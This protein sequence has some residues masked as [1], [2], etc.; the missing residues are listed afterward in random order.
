MMARLEAACQHLRKSGLRITGARIAILKM[1]MRHDVPLS[2]EQIILALGPETCDMVTVYR[3]L[4]TY[5]E[6]G[7]VRRIFS[8]NGTSLWLLADRT[9]A[10]CHV[11]CKGTGAVTTLDP[12]S[13]AEVHALLGKVER[14]LRERGFTEITHMLEFFARAP[15]PPA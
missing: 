13:A 10:A 1:L 7:L 3:T 11:I 6:T 5:L 14:T 15:E 12:E 2:S 4:A 9:D 8:D